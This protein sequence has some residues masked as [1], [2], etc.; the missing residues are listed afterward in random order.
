SRHFSDG[1]KEG[2]LRVYGEVYL[3]E[4]VGR[5]SNKMHLEED[6]PI[7]F[8]SAWQG[9]SAGRS[10]HFS[11]TGGVK[12]LLGRLTGTYARARSH[13]ESTNVGG[14]SV[15][16]GVPRRADD[17]RMYRLRV[18]YR[19]VLELQDNAP[20][21][22]FSGDS[23]ALFLLPLRDAADYNLPVDADAVLGRRPD[24]T[25][26]LRDDP[27]SEPPPGRKL[28]LPDHMTSGKVRGA[29]HSRIDDFEDVEDVW[30]HT[31]EHLRAEGLLPKLVNDVRV[32]SDDARAEASQRRNETLI[33]SQLTTHRLKDGYG[34][35]AQQ[36]YLIRLS[37]QRTG[38]ATEHFHLRVHAE[39]DMDDVKP[40]G[41][42][43]AKPK[44]GLP[45]GSDGASHTTSTGKSRDFGGGLGTGA[46]ESEGVDTSGGGGGYKRSKGRNL[47]LKQGVQ[48][49]EVGL[50][51]AKTAEFSVGTRVW[52]TLE[53]RHVTEQ[54]GR[55]LVD[56]PI[57][58]LP[59]ADGRPAGPTH[60]TSVEAL[61]RGRTVALD[62][63]DIAGLVA[64]RLGV[65]RESVSLDHV[66]ELFSEPGLMGHP[67]AFFSDLRVEVTVDLPGHG[68]TRVPV[69]LRLEARQ[70]HV[71]SAGEWV[72]GDILMSM[73]VSGTSYSTSGTHAVDGSTGLQLPGTP[74][75]EAGLSGSRT[76]SRGREE[77]VIHAG[78]DLDIDTG[79]Q[80]L[81]ETHVVA[82]VSIGASS[83]GEAQELELGGTA[84]RRNTERDVLE[85]YS[86]G[87]MPLSLHQ[88][89]DAAER[90][91]NG[92]L[93]LNR[94]V[95][96]RFVHRYLKDLK[97][98]RN[99]L[100]GRERRKSPVGVPH[101]PLTGEHTKRRFAERME[102]LFD[103]K[104]TGEATSPG[105]QPGGSRKAKPR[106]TFLRTLADALRLERQANRMA[107]PDG[108][109]TAV[110]LSMLGR[111]RL[112][113]P[114]RPEQEVEL[115][116]G[117]TAA[118]D[119]VTPG[120]VEGNV[121]LYRELFTRYAGQRWKGDMDDML[122]PDSPPAIVGEGD[123]RFAVTI[124]ARFGET[125]D[126][127]EV[128][129]K[130]LIKQKYLYGELNESTTVGWSAGG[131]V[132]GADDGSMAASTDREHSSTA[133]RNVQTTRINGLARFKGAEPGV[134]TGLTVVIEVQRL[135]GGK[136]TGPAATVTLQGTM[137]RVLLSGLA[138]REENAP[139]RVR[140]LP[141]PRPVPVPSLVGGMHVEWARADGLA[142]T[143][144]ARAQRKDVLK[145]ELTFAE[146]AKLRKALGRV[147]VRNSLE[148]M[149]DSQGHRVD[150]I[151]LDPNNPDQVVDV[152]V[153]ATFT[154][155]DTVVGDLDD[156][157][158]RTVDRRREKWEVSATRGHLV[159]VGVN[160]G[161]DHKESGAG[162][163][164]AL[165]QQSV[166]NVSVGGGR[167]KE[168][169]VFP[170]G[171][172]SSV[173]FRVDYSVR[174]VVR[175]LADQS[176]RTVE[177]PHAAAG[178]ARIQV[179]TQ[180]LAD[181][182]AEAEREQAPAPA[183]APVSLEQLLNAPAPMSLERLLDR[184]ARRDGFDP[185]RPYVAAARI[186]DAGRPVHL[187]ADADPARPY[188]QLQQ[189]RLLARE[190]GADVTID[191]TTP[192]GTTRTYVADP[193][194]ALRGDTFAPRFAALSPELIQ[195]ADQHGLDLHALH[196]RTAGRDGTLAD[197][198]RS[199][200]R[201]RGIPELT[202]PA[203]AWPV[204]SIPDP[205]DE[206][207]HS[208]EPV[209]VT[210]RPVRGSGG[211]RSRFVVKRRPPGTP[212]MT[213]SEVTKAFFDNV[214]ISDLPGV[215]GWRRTDGDTLVLFTSEHGDV[216]FRVQKPGWVM[217]RRHGWR[218]FRPL[219]RT[220]VRAGTEKQPHLLR[221][222]KNVA[223]DQVARVLVHDIT[224]ALQVQEAR[225]NGRHPQ[226]RL[227]F[228]QQD[229]HDVCAR[230]RLAELSLLRRQLVAADTDARRADLQNEID[231][232]RPDLRD[233]G[234]HLLPGDQIAVRALGGVLTADNRPAW[235]N[236]LT[237]AE[238]RDI[239]ESRVRPN[240]FGSW[241][242]SWTDSGKPAW[243]WIGDNTLLING[244]WFRFE[245]GP[246][247]GGAPAVTRLGMGTV[248][249]PHLVRLAP[250]IAPDQAAF[251]V[252]AA[253]SDTV[254]PTDG[255][256]ATS[257]RDIFNLLARE[258]R[259]TQDP[260]LRA[261]LDT[262]WT[263]LADAAPDVVP[264]RPRSL[265]FN[266]DTR[267]PLLAEHDHKSL[268][269]LR[270]GN[271]YDITPREALTAP[272]WARLRDGLEGDVVDMGAPWIKGSST[273]EVRRLSAARREA[274]LGSAHHDITEFTLRVRYRRH[275]E[276]SEAALLAELS[277]AFDAVDVYF[278]H[279]HRLRDGSQLHVRLEFVEAAGQEPAVTLHPNVAGRDNNL[280]IYAGRGLSVWAHEL[281]HHLGFTDEY[282]EAAKSLQRTLAD[283]LVRRDDSFMAWDRLTW[284]STEEFVRSRRGGTFP[285]RVG[286]RDRH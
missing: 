182:R 61:K 72:G 262:M 84:I 68:K 282:V 39:P 58:L 219:A 3:E 118:L 185:A 106:R 140:A 256:P 179:F 166:D 158:L 25:L 138:T 71:F 74:S 1:Q 206:A 215:H 53:G 197:H 23:R 99:E 224:D 36:G 66:E 12:Y 123:Q 50:D 113:V 63:G 223:P 64:S 121:G 27:S 101:V 57:A 43:P 175:N 6:L 47:S 107:L 173:D 54:K 203:P 270:D 146:Q 55:A 139:S 78:E 273:V 272:Q 204:K 226:R 86:R 115:L 93:Q 283:V 269:V 214:D 52:T 259:A 267:P 89:A 190:I 174:L 237:V 95:A 48:I 157:E 18:R 76:V 31:I 147:A 233:H 205:G 198:V 137:E 109:D 281:G 127:G 271:A 154:D 119:M 188:G 236:D 9:H 132:K 80:Y 276:L 136:P 207:V 177:M 209:T 38:R 120:V 82:H 189:A 172:A 37:M 228:H 69:S 65:P 193:K 24:G 14:T 44:V 29:R 234:H 8:S 11:V 112:H 241:S 94:R 81:S 180:S 218:L 32:Y 196:D 266:S 151:Q 220:K 221:L 202:P 56:V 45:I 260:A 116:E 96:M 144:I 274:G 114:G 200:L 102:E 201:R 103:Q 181:N 92:S 232:L 135:T 264:P 240:D 156:T 183:T 230:S 97:Q 167:R 286:P 210:A 244:Q 40:V 268:A 279:Q 131:N 171:V 186:L 168:N 42:S 164:V 100:S 194:G 229:G 250:R 22:S 98:A 159:P 21:K 211:K 249:D 124:R 227:L 87:E 258:Y 35:A 70:S 125:D 51:E 110:G 242:R 117:V 187:V 77:T 128:Y 130:G 15:M 129:D 170:K 161:E 176:E 263:A 108:Y 184:A 162:G 150:T 261:R 248:Q 134:L 280:N 34:Q 149:A 217:M 246:I 10:G 142:D 153:Q 41:P 33:E 208:V 254:W 67:E 122:A 126:H 133:S 145:R 238:A 199:E 231:L 243:K 75:A 152:Y 7:G 160:V 4:V 2:T 191:V 88:A 222:N 83:L 111:T 19:A 105:E 192:D 247:D 255:Q 195:V 285:A 141:D 163:N 275:P 79:M 104:S 257:H 30:K 148:A 26:I 155:P 16:P 13:G 213:V 216:H 28:E 60:A 62:M 90:F 251:A 85:L 143:V 169:S 212:K 284:S 5:R 225:K 245:V 73:Q 239:F 91:L 20:R 278:N 252:L 59:Y 277:N 17:T 235:Q 46:P 253:V 178:T 165:H 49:N 265:D